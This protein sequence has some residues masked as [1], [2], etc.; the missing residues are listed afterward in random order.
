V[1]KALTKSFPFHIY[2]AEEKN[3]RSRLQGLLG[4]GLLLSL[5]L[6]QPVNAATIVPG[7]STVDGQTLGQWSNDWFKWALS[8]GPGPFSDTD[9]SRANI[10]QA[11]PVFYL[12]GT[13]AG[14][15]PVTRNITVTD[16]KL[17]YFPLIN[18]LVANGP[19]AGFPDTKTEAIALATNTINPA[20]LFATIDGT[21][22]ANLASHR[23]DSGSLFTLTMVNN[24]DFGFP[25]GTYTD[26]YEDGYW[27]M[28]NPLSAGQH[29]LHFGG[30]G[31]P[32]NAGAFQVDPFAID[33]TVNLNVVAAPGGGTAAPLPAGLF[34]G[35]ACLVP[36]LGLR[37]KFCKK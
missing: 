26:A 1:T 2:F 22:V 12:A 25:A 9:G 29:T 30:T 31:T 13:G 6:A 23:E 20:N 24:N 11:G 3:M 36:A 35:L 17:I 7:Q 32:F 33:V 19:D 34:C 37:R 10:N 4:F 16:D 8:Y 28:V 15:G 18:W 14:A 5:G 21:P 27:L